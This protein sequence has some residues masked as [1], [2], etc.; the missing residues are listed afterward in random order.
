VFWAPPSRWALNA[1]W[2]L[3]ALLAAN[4]GI[5]TAVRLKWETNAS[6]TM[7][8]QLSDLRQSDREILFY[9]PSFSVSIEGRLKAWGITYKIGDRNKVGTGPRLLTIVEDYPSPVRYRLLPQAATRP[10]E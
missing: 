4:A 9:I 5:V 2:I 3:V 10:A 8:R 6:L 1:A 7:R